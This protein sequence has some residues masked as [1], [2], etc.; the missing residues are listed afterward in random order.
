MDTIRQVMARQ[1]SIRSKLGFTVIEL[2]LI[3]VVMGF[4]VLLAM[5]IYSRIVD[6]SRE[7]RVI[8]NAYTLHLQ[9]EGQIILHH[10]PPANHV[11]LADSLSA[12]VTLPVNPFTGEETLI[13]P[14]GAYSRGN[15]GYAVDPATQIFRV[16][17]YGA[18]ETGGPSGDGVIVALEAY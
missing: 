9:V 7:G 11:A 2:A 14:A 8:A 5:P 18:N 17:G 1:E 15:L 12:I 16:E 4:L 6:R 3:V 10:A 13:G